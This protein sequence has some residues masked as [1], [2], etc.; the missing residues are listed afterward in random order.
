MPMRPRVRFPL[1]EHAP[2]SR[3]AP[4]LPFLRALKDS[5]AASRV[6][7]GLLRR[8]TRRARATGDPGHL[9]DTRALYAVERRVLEALERGEAL[10]ESY[11]TLRDALAFL[12]ETAKGPA[13]REGNARLNALER[14]ARETVLRSYPVSAY[15]ELTTRCNLRCP[16]CTQ[17]QIDTPERPEMTIEDVERLAPV[18]Q[19]LR[20]LRLFGFG[21]SLLVDYLDRVLELVPDDTHT[22]INTNGVPL[23]RERAEMLV[24]GGLK[25]IGISLDA[26]D[27]ETYRAIRG[28]DAFDRVVKNARRLIEIKRAAGAEFPY[29][30]FIFV[31]MRRNIEQLADYVRLVRDIGGQGIGVTYL[32]VYFESWRSESLFYH[33]ELAE[34]CFDEAEKAAK[35]TGV[36]L[37]LPPRFSDGGVDAGRLPCAEPW[38][39][40]YFR[41]DGD[42][43]P[44]CAYNKPFGS[45]RDE[46]FDAVWNNAAYQRL[47]GVINTDAE[48]GPCKQCR[49]VFFR[50]VRDERTHIT[51]MESIENLQ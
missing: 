15:L 32:N 12:R 28:A 38:R 20:E 40:V 33:Q 29:V 34:R 36:D 25:E 9:S 45:W 46:S 10:D 22:S 44:C 21:E 50:N 16:I 23:T 18:L 48:P 1:P 6:L 39:F 14:V 43:A 11:A 27:P 49:H 3:K 31:A 30:S 47:R 17:S 7:L 26:T 42:L 2:S 51:L 4:L 19:W 5:P 13:M 8:A 35:E 24:R 37:L 41:A